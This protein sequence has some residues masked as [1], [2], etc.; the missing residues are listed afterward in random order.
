MGQNGSFWFVFLSVGIPCSGEV[1]RETPLLSQTHP[2]QRE[3]STSALRPAFNHL[4]QYRVLLVTIGQPTYEQFDDQRSC[5]SI[6]Q[7]CGSTDPEWLCQLKCRMNQSTHSLAPVPRPLKVSLRVS[8]AKDKFMSLFFGTPHFG[9]PLHLYMVARYPL[10]SL[11]NSF[12]STGDP[13]INAARNFF[14]VSSPSV[15][16]S[17]CSS[18][19][20]RSGLQHRF[21][22]RMPIGTRPLVD[23]TFLDC[24]E[25][26][27]MTLSSTPL[28]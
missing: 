26:L 5:S 24:F 8:L 11:L 15:Y 7:G 25:G 23:P 1:W 14:W 13:P 21:C 22:P 19:S 17:V 20:F 6:Q 18:S 16:W 9:S 4:Q 3:L 27:K 12:F 28:W 10:E 2:H